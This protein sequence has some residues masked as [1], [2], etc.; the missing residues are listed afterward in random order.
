MRILSIDQAR[1]GAWAI[2]E[3]ETKTLLDK[4]VFSF[5]SRKFPFAKAVLGIERIV[6]KILKEKEVDVIFIEDIQLRVNPQAF[7]HLA[8][9][10][11]VL[12]NLFEKNEFLYDFVAPTQWQ[13]YCKKAICEPCGCDVKKMNSK[14]LSLFCAEKLFDIHTHNDNLADAI[15]LGWYVVNNI[16]FDVDEK[17]N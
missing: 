9:L 2:F 15:C 8:Q 12:V 11:G 16:K 7:K 13:S 17:E 1:N 4:G 6:E 5:D 3:Y 10:Q 14:E